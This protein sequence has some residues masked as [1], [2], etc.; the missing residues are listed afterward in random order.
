MGNNEAN[1]SAKY[2]IIPG[3]NDNK[4]E[5]ENWIKA[6]KNDGLSYTILDIEEKWF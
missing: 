4:E 5:I 3:I 6:N 1:V 2:I